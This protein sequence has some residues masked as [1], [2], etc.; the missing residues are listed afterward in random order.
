MREKRFGV[1][2]AGGLAIG[3]LSFGL[4]IALVLFVIRPSIERGTHGLRATREGEVR[5]WTDGRM[6]ADEVEAVRAE[7]ERLWRETAEAL[8]IELDAFPQP[9]DVFL[10]R[11]VDDLIDAVV[12]RDSDYRSVQWAILDRLPWEDPR[13]R[14]A[15]LVLAY[16]WG[17]CTSQ[18]LHAGM[19]L[20]AAHPNRNFH[21]FVAALPERSRHSVDEL[22][23]LETSGDFPRTYY[24]IYDSP[25]AMRFG[26]SLAA[27]KRHYDIPRVVLANPEQQQIYLESASLVQYLIEERHSIE[28]LRAVWDVG[29]TANLLDRLTGCTTGELTREWHAAAEGRGIGSADYDVQRIVLLIESGDCDA[30]YE[31]SRSWSI[32]NA[33]DEQLTWMILTSILGGDLDR[34]REM[35][36]EAASRGTAPPSWAVSLVNGTVAL[37]GSA[38]IVACEA[39]DAEDLAAIQSTVGAVRHDLGLTDDDL[40]ETITVLVH[41]DEEALEDARPT[42]GRHGLPSALVQVVR[43]EDI[44][45]AVATALPTYALGKTRSRLLERGFALATSGD[46]SALAARAAALRATPRWQ[47]L[48]ELT[49]M[50]HDE[51][52]VDIQAALL[53]RTILDAFGTETLRAVWR[54]TSTLGGGS[55]LDTA[56][57]THAGVTRHELEERHLIL[58]SS[59][60]QDSQPNSERTSYRSLVFCHALSVG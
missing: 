7:T 1:S 20:V 3:F 41:E 19:T 10:H 13:T 47:S 30:A 31:T 16:G 36:A 11:S 32:G 35:L 37:A 58:E 42:L 22:I 54:S 57:K 60:P 14:I 34:G 44:A 23:S 18:V 48:G 8:D 21:T 33:S 25:H 45:R 12:N 55:C 6:Q 46:R 38:R 2:L 53:V 51:S 17:E 43:G 27:T 59:S 5:V 49:Y 15:E 50:G 29:F 26:L 40:P 56:L 4:A 52:D 24:Q 39:I 28:A 9:I